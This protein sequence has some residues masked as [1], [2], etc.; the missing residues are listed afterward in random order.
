M[1]R[2]LIG[3]VR[4]EHFGDI[5][6]AEPISRYVREQ[7]PDAHIVWF[8]KPGF[9]ELVS[10]NPNVDEVFK[11]FCVTERR[12]LL[13]GNVFDKVIE[14]QFTNNNYCPKCQVFIDNPMALK[15]DINI[16]NYFDY[17]NLLEVFAQTGDLIPPK[18]AFPADDQPRLYL[19]P[20]H[21]AKVDSLGLP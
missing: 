2:E 20:S 18:A 9:A 21:Q 11:E 1:G 3:I 12:V 16:L 8:V 6:A 10:H 19:Q 4:T 7:Y 13:E 14:L 15:R 17:G 5:V